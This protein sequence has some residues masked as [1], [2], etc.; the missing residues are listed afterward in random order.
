MMQYL[1]AE[2]IGVVIQFNNA[3]EDQAL[4]FLNRENIR[5]RKCAT[6]SIDDKISVTHNDEIKFSDSVINLE[7]VWSKA[8]PVLNH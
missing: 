4:E 7:K 2:E 6:Q 3:F 8:S 1:F 5:Y